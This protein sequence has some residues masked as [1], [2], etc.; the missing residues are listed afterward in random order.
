VGGQ[1]VS[2]SKADLEALATQVPPRLDMSMRSSV[3][4]GVALATAL[5]ASDSCSPTSLATCPHTCSTLR[6]ATHAGADTSR[7]VLHQDA[8]L[9]HGL[10]PRHLGHHP[11]KPPRGLASN[12]RRASGGLSAVS[13]EYPVMRGHPGGSSSLRGHTRWKASP[14]PSPGKGKAVTRVWGGGYHAACDTCRAWAWRAEGDVAVRKSVKQLV[15]GPT[16]REVTSH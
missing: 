16:V 4:P 2:T 3:I 7:T 12:A 9:L 13:L 11:A 5:D 8:Y 6:R 15:L 1:R 10:P 14:S